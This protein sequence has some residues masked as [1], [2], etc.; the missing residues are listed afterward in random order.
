LALID[1]N[2]SC[3]SIDSFHFTGST[4]VCKFP[5]VSISFLHAQAQ[6][7][8]SFWTRVETDHIQPEKVRPH[9]GKQSAARSK[10]GQSGLILEQFIV[11]ETIRYY[12]ASHNFEVSPL[13]KLLN[14]SIGNRQ[15]RNQPLLWRIWKRNVKEKLNFL[16]AWNCRIAIWKC[17]KT[18]HKWS[19]WVFS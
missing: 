18:I 5:V 12:A 19:V 17:V 3:H 16:S 14:D 1:S 4:Y 2:I 7:W 6:K 8:P 10:K 15:T 9:F 11:S 13:I